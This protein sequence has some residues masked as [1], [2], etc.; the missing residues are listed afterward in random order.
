MDSFWH[1]DGPRANKTSKSLFVGPPWCNK[2]RGQ[3]QP[4]PQKNCIKIAEHTIRNLIIFVIHLFIDLVLILWWCWQAGSK[5]G[6]KRYPRANIEKSRQVHHSHARASFLMFG[7]SPKNNLNEN[8][9]LYKEAKPCYD[10]WMAINRK[11]QLGRTTME[12]PVLVAQEKLAAEIYGWE[13]YLE[14]MIENNQLPKAYETHLN[15]PR[16]MNM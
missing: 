8:L 16:A 2:V 3:N 9:E 6:T 15:K 5:K 14:R 1:L 4:Q 7:A 11:D 10:F 13:T 12:F